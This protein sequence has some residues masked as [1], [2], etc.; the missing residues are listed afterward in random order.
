MKIAHIVCKF[1]PYQSGMGNVAFEQAQRLAKNHQVV[2]FALNQGKRK[3]YQH[4]FKIVW[5]KPLIHFGNGGLCLSLFWKLKNFDIIQLHYPFFGA[6]EII[7]LGKF[8]KIL[9]KPKLIIF[10]HMDAKLNNI[11]LKILSLPSKLINRGLFMRADRVICS[12]FDYIRHSKIKS[13]YQKHQKKFVEIPF[14]VKQ[15]MPPSK[16]KESIK[17]GKTVLFVSNL[18]KAHYFKGVDVLINAFKIVLGRINSAKLVIVGD[19]DLRKKYENLAKKLNIQ[20]KVTFAGFVEDKELA[21]YYQLCDICVVPAINTSEAFSLILIEAKSFGKAVIA[22]DLPGVRYVAID[23]QS[24]FLAKPGDID[25]LAQKM[26]ELL[27]NDKLRLE[28]GEKGKQTVEQKYNWDK[29]VQKLEA[30]YFQVS[31]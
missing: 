2:V 29:H 16:K 11:L 26:T 22:S 24:G 9:K 19:G 10:Y 3:T 1:P 14:G 8:L 17:G 25:D 6:G 27:K 30:V 15:L 28:M 31:E 13:I 20:D 18:D 12:T 4:N 21:D 7:W 23:N 5:L